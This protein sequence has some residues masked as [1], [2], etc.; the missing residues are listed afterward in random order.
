[1]S[2]YHLSKLVRAS[3]FGQTKT[4]YK[5]KI[6]K[7]KHWPDYGFMLVDTRLYRVGKIICLNSQ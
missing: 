1:M 7:Q 3:N 6:G 2:I 5:G 4:D